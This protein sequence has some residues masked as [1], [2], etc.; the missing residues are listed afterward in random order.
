MS[1]EQRESTKI[2]IL[3]KAIPCGGTVYLDDIEVAS[4]NTLKV[5]TPSV[6]KGYYSFVVDNEALKETTDER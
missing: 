2:G 6:V 5:G 1:E 4:G 3:N